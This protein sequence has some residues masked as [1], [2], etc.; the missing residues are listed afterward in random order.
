CDIGTV[1]FPKFDINVSSEVTSCK[2]NGHKYRWDSIT[3]GKKP[4]T[5]R[6]TLEKYLYVATESSR[7]QVN[8]AKSEIGNSIDIKWWK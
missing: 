6:D 5:L 8:E 7:S 2:W 1:F 4:E 3:F